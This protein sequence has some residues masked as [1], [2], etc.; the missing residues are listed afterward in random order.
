MGFKASCGSGEI[1]G[2]RGRRLTV[3]AGC[4][5]ALA[6]AL[7][8]AGPSGAGSDPAPRDAGGLI[9]RFEPGVSASV[10]RHVLA[11]HGVASE[12][13]L[14]RTGL[15]LVHAAS[16][17]VAAALENE[18]QVRYVEED[19]VYPLA[20]TPNDPDFGQMWG[21]HAAPDDDDI[22][23]PEAWDLTTGASV[24]VAVIDTGVA[25]THPDLS[26]NVWTNTSETVNG[27]DD[28]GNGLVDDI[29]GWD[30]FDG[31]N[32]P[33]DVDEHGTHVAGTIG[34]RGNNSVGVVG[35]NW[36]VRLMALRAGDQIGLPLSAIV[37]SIDYAC[38][39]GARVVNGSFGGPS[40]SQAM[41]DAINTCPGTLFVF[42]AGN[43]GSDQIGD[44]ND[45]FPTYP[46][47]YPSPNIVCVAATTRGD[48][49]AGFS[50]YG[51]TSVDL[52]APGVAILSTKPGGSYQFGDGTSMASPHVA[53]VAALRLALSPAA[54][55]GQLKNALLSSV[56]TKA[57]LSG[58]VVSGGR[59]NAF[60][61]MNAP[62]V[63]PPPPPPPPPPPAPVDN[64]PPSDPAVISLTHTRGVPSNNPSITLSWA[65]ASD[66]GSGV[67]GY[68]YQWDSNATGMPDL[69][70]D[71]EET[72]ELL[73][74]SLPRGATYYFHLRTRDNA[75][76]W[77]AGTHVGPFVLTAA[78]PPRP[79]VRCVVPRV[80]GKTLAAARSALT[81][82]HCALGR[83]TKRR[84]RI[85][86]G[87]VVTQSVR[88]GTR[89][90][91]GFRVGVTVSRGRR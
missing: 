25:Y 24:L 4:L 7:A 84:S 14:A 16:P 35:V 72:L 3:L 76:N 57:A 10:R 55:V 30:F 31:D 45:S 40:F 70:K 48:I 71:A 18:P 83:V 90:P 8:A 64:V 44:N 2:V 91:R 68:S 34:A 46:C 32:D 43:G 9:V 5:G 1:L 53:G 69:I 36:Q 88:T 54:T 59:L 49:L 80:T 60:G 86:R 62:L 19:R 28:D 61:A 39:K 42:A 27:L 75:G 41:L 23:A 33:D 56:D 51:A 89:R 22:D 73:T 67:D 13:S 11:E 81:R 77:S 50:N 47:N 66:F 79:A 85:R 58:K 21:L 38:S 82:S 65:G 74:T 6:F 29:R 12:R 26:Q 78:P 52:A 63:E 37:D 87:R 17:S 15:E 20:A